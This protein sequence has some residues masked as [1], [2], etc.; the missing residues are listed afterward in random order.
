M[1]AGML[2]HVE[3]V[4]VPGRATIV[5]MRD[6]CQGEAWR[7]GKYGRQVDHRRVRLQWR[8]QV[9]DFQFTGGKLFKQLC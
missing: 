3:R 2:T 7:R 8:G 6:L 5:V 4:P 9:D 1:G